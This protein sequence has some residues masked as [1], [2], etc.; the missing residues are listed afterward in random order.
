MQVT[1]CNKKASFDICNSDSMQDADN[2]HSEHVAHRVSVQFVGKGYQFF[3]DIVASIEVDSF[4]ESLSNLLGDCMNLL[5]LIDICHSSSVG[6][7]A[8]VSHA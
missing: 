1:T 5:Q 7:S 8:S 2:H 4:D 3:F 6:K